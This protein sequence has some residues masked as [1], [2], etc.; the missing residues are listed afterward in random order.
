MQKRSNLHIFP[1]SSQVNFFHFPSVLETLS[2]ETQRQMA[3]CIHWPV[4]TG[5]GGVPWILGCWFIINVNFDTLTAEFGNF[6]SRCYICWDILLRAPCFLSFIPCSL[7]NSFYQQ[8]CHSEFCFENNCWSLVDSEIFD[9][10]VKDGND[11]F[12]IYE[13]A[14]LL[15]VVDSCHAIMHNG[16]VFQVQSLV[17][18]LEFSADVLARMKVTSFGRPNGTNAALMGPPHH[19][20]FCDLCYLPFLVQIE[21][22]PL[23]GFWKQSV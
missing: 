22:I 2:P 17:V 19:G 16:K 6:F 7:G 13:V 4:E 9:N 15:L 12:D 18:I 8:I 3:G 21:R 14:T 5:E 11:A 10:D 23:V 1:I 20:Q